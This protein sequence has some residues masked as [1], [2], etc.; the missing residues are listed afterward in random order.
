MRACRSEINTDCF[1]YRPPLTTTLLSLGPPHGGIWTHPP[2]PTPPPLV[3]SSRLYRPV[4]RF[5]LRTQNAE[6]RQTKRLPHG[7]SVVCLKTHKN[8]HMKACSAPLTLPTHYTLTSICV[9]PPPPRIYIQYFSFYIKYI[10]V[11]VVLHVFTPYVV[12]RER[13]LDS[14]RLAVEECFSGETTIN[15]SA[16]AVGWIQVRSVS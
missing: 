10:Q 9:C 2:T 15:P 4:F 14:V 12:L 8:L 5:P 6:G 7:T 1:A 11:F 3:S 16:G 13:L